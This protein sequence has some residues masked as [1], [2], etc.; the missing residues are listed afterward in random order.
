[1][2]RG[3]GAIGHRQKGGGKKGDQTRKERVDPNDVMILPFSDV[4]RRHVM[5]DLSSTYTASTQQGCLQGISTWSTANVPCNE[6]LI[7]LN[8][9]HFQSIHILTT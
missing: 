4:E 3:E 5:T 2:F 1:M 7:I 6:Y 9:S 8:K